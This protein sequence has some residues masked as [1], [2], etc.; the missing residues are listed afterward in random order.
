M[1]TLTVGHGSTFQFQTIAA[2]IAASASGD[3]IQIQAGNY[4]DDYAPTI[5]HDLTI[6]GVGGQVQM[7]ATAANPPP[8]EKGILAIGAQGANP[9]V[10]VQNVTFRNTVISDNSG[11]NGAGIRYQGGDLTLIHDGFVNNQDGLLAD[12]TRPAP[13]PSTGASF[14]TTGREPVRPTTSMSTMWAR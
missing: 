7:I 3:T 9:N 11:G 4:V 8:N 6:V 1:A 14:T 5:T 13:S 2:A 12:P 10:T